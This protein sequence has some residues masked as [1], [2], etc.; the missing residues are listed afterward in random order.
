MQLMHSKLK[1]DRGKA[2]AL[3]E[4]T[5]Y[6]KFNLFVGS[7]PITM[8]HHGK[9]HHN[10]DCRRLTDKLHKH[11]WT[12]ANREKWAYIPDDIDASTVQ[13]TFAGFLKECNIELESRFSA[14]VVQMRIP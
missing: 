2:P 13:T 14:P 7:Q 12:D 6:L 5:G 8:L 1:S 4:A 10:P 11:R 3:T 9:V